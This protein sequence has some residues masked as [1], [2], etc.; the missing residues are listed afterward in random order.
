M[1]LAETIFVADTPV[2]VIRMD[3]NTR[4]IAF[5]PIEGKSRLPDREWKSIDE[6]K[7]AVIK[8]YRG[9]SK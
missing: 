5:S 4:Q 7:D 8:T 3:T 1:I 6:L 2:G 9:K